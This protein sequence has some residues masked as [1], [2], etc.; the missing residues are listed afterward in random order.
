VPG[1][2][3]PIPPGHSAPMTAVT[4]TG[5]AAAGAALAILLGLLAAR[6]AAAQQA[7]VPASAFPPPERPVAGIVT[8]TW[9]NEASRDNA[10]EAGKVF[11]LLGIRPGLVVADIGAGSGYDT[12]RLAPLVAPGGTAPAGH[13]YAEDIVPTYVERLARRIAEL[14]LGGIVTVVAGEPADPR[15]P[16]GAIDLALMVHMYHEIE[17]PFGLLWNLRPAL[18]PGA[19]VAI[20]DALRPTERHGTPPALLRC[21]LAAVGYRETASYPLDAQSYLAVFVPQAMPASPAAIRPCP[22]Q[23]G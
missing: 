9:S 8:D 3:N 4:A 6:S 18:R 10:G 1:L 17:Q 7:G 22:N 12:V 5:R 13:V 23:P 2:D 14:R 21:E 15:L 20:V 19:R 11:G 16:P